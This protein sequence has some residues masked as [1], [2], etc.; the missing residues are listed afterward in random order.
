MK[1][2]KTIGFGLFIALVSAYLL[3]IISPKIFTGFYPFGIR[4]A[5]VLTGSMSPTIEIN[6]FVIVKKPS[7][8][9]VGDIVSYKENDG[10]M[11]VLHRVVKIE[12]GEITTKGDANNIEDKPVEISQ[13]TGVYVGK[14][15][16]LG[17]IISFIVQPVVFSIIIVLLLI[18]LFAPYKK[19]KV[20]QKGKTKDGK[21]R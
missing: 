16:Y 5:V 2:L 18:I 12:D 6:D 14:I 10:G 17:K 15:E 19:L 11:E 13:V 4:T 20:F 9:E 3:I 1:V 8:I 7:E 21:K